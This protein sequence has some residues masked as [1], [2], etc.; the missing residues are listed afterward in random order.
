MLIIVTNTHEGLV[1]F[2]K[3]NKLYNIQKHNLLKRKKI[4]KLI[5]LSKILQQAAIK[6]L[7]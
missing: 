7:H 4:K 6:I 3:S 1:N 2:S 5:L